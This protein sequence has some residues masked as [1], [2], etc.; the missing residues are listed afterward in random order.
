M[1][2]VEEGERLVEELG[3]DLEQTGQ[4]R[5]SATIGQRATDGGRGCGRLTEQVSSRSRSSAGAGESML[6]RGLALAVSVS[7]EGKCGLSRQ[8]PPESVRQY[9]QS[10]VKGKR[11]NKTLTGRR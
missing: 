2:A 8:V 5:R 10:I 6:R 1:E 11:K 9:R 3:A 4:V 7:F